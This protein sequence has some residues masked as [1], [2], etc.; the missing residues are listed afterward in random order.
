MIG[1]D[2]LPPVV[3]TL[4]GNITDFQAKMGE[5][6]VEMDAVGKKGGSVFNQLATVGKGAL[7][8]LGAAAVA[9]GGLSLKMADDFEKAHVQLEVAVRNTRGNFDA[10][11]PRISAIDKQFES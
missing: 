7:L 11:S 2:F 10:L 5:A 8:G 9:V 6:K 3:A 1:G 4:L